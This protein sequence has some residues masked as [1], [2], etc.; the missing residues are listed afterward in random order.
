MNVLSQKRNPKQEVVISKGL[1]INKWIR[2]KEV[3]VIDSD[4]AQLGVMEI[5][6]ARNLAVK[7]EL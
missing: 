6:N 1:R 5:Y 2:A 3:R 7:Q 4:G